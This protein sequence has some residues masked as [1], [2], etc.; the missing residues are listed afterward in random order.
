MRSC[1]SA[2]SAGVAM[3]ATPAGRAEGRRL[4]RAGAGR[5]SRG[6]SGQAGGQGWA[7]KGGGNFKGAVGAEI[8]IQG[9]RK[10]KKGGNL[11]CGL[12]LSVG[13]SHI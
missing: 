12:H 5:A 6:D 10:E 2:G 3:Q 13:R 1:A 11:T 7:A 9:G 8:L 4:Q